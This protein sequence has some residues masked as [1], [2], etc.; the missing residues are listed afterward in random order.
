MWWLTTKLLLQPT[1][2]V[3]LPRSTLGHVFEDFQYI[4]HANAELS[5]R[6]DPVCDQKCS[7]QRKLGWCCPACSSRISGNT[8]TQIPKWLDDFLKKSH[9]P[10]WDIRSL[11]DLRRSVWASKE[12]KLHHRSAVMLCLK[13]K[14]SQKKVIVTRQIHRFRFFAALEH[15]QEALP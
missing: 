4:C 7:Y 8:S 9:P 15:S 14:P 10:E 6:T 5:N 3:D 1:T 12:G 2:N 13:N 11:R